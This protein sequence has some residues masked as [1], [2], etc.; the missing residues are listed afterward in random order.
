MSTGTCALRGRLSGGARDKFAMRG[1]LSGV[2]CCAG[3]HPAP[4]GVGQIHALL[5]S[6]FILLSV[7]SVVSHAP[8]D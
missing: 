5:R 6:F 7:L 3:E 2:V 1:V 4:R 8:E